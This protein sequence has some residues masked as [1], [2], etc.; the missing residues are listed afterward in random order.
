MKYIKTVV[1]FASSR[2]TGG[3]CVAGKELHEGNPGTWIRPVSARPTHEIYQTEMRCDD[4]TTPRV[5][6]VLAVPCEK[7]QPISHQRENYVIDPVVSWKKEGRIAW[8]DIRKWTD[9]P[10]SLW[11]LGNESSTGLNN[12]LS[13]GQEDG[14]SLYLVETDQL[15]LV[16]GA[17]YPNKR[18]VVRGEFVY[19]GVSYLMDITDPEI[20]REYL[21]NGH[22]D[23]GKPDGQYDIIRP[24]LCVSLGDPFG[25]HFYKLI[26]AVLYK[27]RFS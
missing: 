10:S 16:V 7:H 5:L 13:A 6:D 4:G 11:G 9:T 3:F 24:V 22:N 1:C 23:L 27:E 2:K 20:E 12:R 21:G 15:C 26:A 14:T 25:G 18:R 19:R 17:K 8:R